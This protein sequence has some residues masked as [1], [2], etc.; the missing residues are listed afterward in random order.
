MPFFIKLRKKW[1]LLAAGTALLAALVA[2][3]SQIQQQIDKVQEKKAA[4]ALRNTGFGQSLQNA[5]SKIEGANSLFEMTAEYKSRAE[6]LEKE[7]GDAWGA[8]QEA[9]KNLDNAEKLLNQANIAEIERRVRMFETVSLAFSNLDPA[10]VDE[11]AS[12]SRT[13]IKLLKKRYEKLKLAISDEKSVIF[14]RI[15][16]IEKR[17]KA[18]LK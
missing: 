11:L 1:K 7:N 9:W 15:D 17:N 14:A 4:A 18:A 10:W 2:G 12:S 16:G 8:Y 5:K 6:K 13:W 3:Q